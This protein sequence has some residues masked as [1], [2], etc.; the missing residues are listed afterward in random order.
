MSGG[1]HTCIAKACYN[2]GDQIE[3]RIFMIRI[4]ALL[5]LV[6]PGIIAAYGIKMM[7]DMVFGITIRPFTSSLLWLQFIS[8]L[9]LFL[10]GLAFIG[11]FIL[12]RDRKKNK[13][14]NRFKLDK[15]L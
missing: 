6:I 9:L 2:I 4:I 11:G 3:M 13:V 12:H 7:R 15:K 5:I 1:R 8:G 10:A 14:Q